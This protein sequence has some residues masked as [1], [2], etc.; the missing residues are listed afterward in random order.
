MAVILFHRHGSVTDHSSPI[1]HHYTSPIA[2]CSL[3]GGEMFE[4][5]L[6]AR[7]HRY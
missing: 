7:P 5:K 4:V 1:I 6:D 3:R 2:P